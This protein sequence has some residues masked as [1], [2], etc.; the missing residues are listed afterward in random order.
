MLINSPSGNISDLEGLIKELC[1]DDNLAARRKEADYQAGLLTSEDWKKY[2]YLC[3]HNL[4][5]LATTVLGYDK[6]SPTL[7][8]H[9]CRWMEE[10]DRDQFREFLLPRGHYKSTIITVAD[11][12][13]AALPDDS[14]TA[15]WPRN[16]G[17]DIK[18]CIG[19]EVHESACRFLFA[20]S[21]HFLSNPLLMGLF[22][23]CVPNPKRQRVNK[24]ELELPRS[25]AGIIEPTFDTIGVGGRAQGRHYN[26]LKMDDLFGD[27]AR[28]SEA[29]RK[30]TYD[31]FDNIQSFFSS[32]KDDHL[33][34]IGTRWAMDDIYAHAHEMYEDDLKKYIRS[35]EEINPKTG[36]KEP[37]FPEE[38]PQD[39]L[40]ILKRKPKI[41][42]AQYA[43][44]PTEGSN[45]FDKSSKRFFYWGR[46]KEIIT[47]DGR[48]KS[49][50][51]DCYNV[52]LI[53]PAPQHEAGYLVTGMDEKRRAFVY[54]AVKKAFKPAE[55]VEE[56]F[57]DVQKFN[58]DLV[59]IEAVNFSSLYEAWLINEMPRR[60]IR[61]AT[62]GAKTGNKEK[63]LRVDGL[64]EYYT[65]GQIYYQENQ[66]DLIYEHDNYGSIK[67]FHLL[68]AL[69]YGPRYWK[70]GV[71]FKRKQQMEKESQEVVAD[72]D[73]D[74]GYSANY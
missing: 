17:P 20:I 30:S 58:V 24:Q 12:I 27:K 57:R 25:K 35:C 36:L 41:Y 48:G 29:E 38:F 72:R 52:I 26:Y 10:S 74:T 3:K 5:F 16:L 39:K 7:H 1:S 21:T 54:K 34:L 66:I 63:E 14:G 6:L 28:D 73:V 71:S 11:S 44:D 42:S 46:H 23:E 15:P 67:E 8:G 19:H 9:L 2:R 64:E 33:D 43:N 69:A 50:V 47:L 62:E 70:P 45:K 49:H 13:R 68:D 59:V 55:L 65:A 51:D 37:I 31:W 4:W 60:G 18:L 56:V 22:P 40:K 53:D 61:F 32:F